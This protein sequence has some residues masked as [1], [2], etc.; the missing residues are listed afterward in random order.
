[1]DGLMR[2]LAL[3]LLALERKEGRAACTERAVFATMVQDGILSATAG[4]TFDYALRVAKEQGLVGME[5]QGI[6]E[7]VIWW[8]IELH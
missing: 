6:D 3:T 1:M 4:Q 7:T 2:S 5:E 8:E